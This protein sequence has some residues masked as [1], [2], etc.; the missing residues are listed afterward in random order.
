MEV[1]NI[2]EEQGGE[3]AEYGFYSDDNGDPVKINDHTYTY[4]DVKEDVQ[5]HRWNTTHLFVFKRED[6]KL[7]GM[8]YDIGLTESQENGFVYN[9]PELYEVNKI[10]EVVT[11]VSYKKSK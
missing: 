10:E 2:T 9:H 4:Y 3:L 7:F 1:I 6:G 5:D 11:K 8:L